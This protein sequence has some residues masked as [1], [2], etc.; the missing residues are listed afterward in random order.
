ML[1]GCSIT[2]GAFAG[3]PG[4]AVPGE[5]SFVSPFPAGEGG[6]VEVFMQ[7]ACGPLHPRFLRRTLSVLT[8][9]KEPRCNENYL[10]I[11]KK[12]LK[13]PADCAILIMDGYVL[14]TE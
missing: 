2:L 10:R 6:E 14:R 4:T 8:D 11:L 7:G 13:F 3:E 9:V 5:K 1:T 12:T